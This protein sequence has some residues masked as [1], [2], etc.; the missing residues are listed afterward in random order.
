MSLPQYVTINGTNY[1]TEKLPQAALEQVANVQIVDAEI[2]RLQNQLGIA[3]TAKSIYVSQLLEAMKTAKTEQ[4]AAEKKPAGK[5][6]VA[7]PAPVEA[8]TPAKKTRA[9]KAV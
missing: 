6:K 3:Q 5:S 4:P 2:Q 1:A 9:K 8:A 7:E